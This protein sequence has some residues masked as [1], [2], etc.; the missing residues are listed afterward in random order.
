[1]EPLSANQCIWLLSLF[2]VKLR[3]IGI[4]MKISIMGKRS[5]SASLSIAT[6]SNIPILRV[7]YPK[8]ALND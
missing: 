1:M 7:D 2:A 3:V 4:R 5:S 8:A 6:Q